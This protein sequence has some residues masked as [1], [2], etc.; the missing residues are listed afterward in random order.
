MT[1]ASQ[2]LCELNISNHGDLCESELCE[3]EKELKAVLVSNKIAPLPFGLL[4]RVLFLLVPTLVLCLLS[5]P[6]S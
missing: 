5:S 3:S 2:K 1:Y 6:S 4:L